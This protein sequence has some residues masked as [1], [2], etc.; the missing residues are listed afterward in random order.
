MRKVLPSMKA[1]KSTSPPLTRQRPLSPHLQ[2]YRPQITSML[3]IMQRLTGVPLAGGAVL[4][5]YWLSSAAYGPDAFARAQAL[6]GSWVGQVVLFGL[7]FALFYHLCNG[8]RHLLWDIGFGFD[9][10]TLRASGIIMV[11][12]ALTLTAAVWISVL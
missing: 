10:P 1:D 12:T 11:T 9:M 2:V 3:S 5:A 4:L 7:T 6:F 8:I